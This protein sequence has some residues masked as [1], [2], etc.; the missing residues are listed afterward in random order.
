[1]KGQ[2]D[3]AIADFTETIRLDPQYARAYLGRGSSWLA[4]R[5]FDKALADAEAAIRIDPHDPT[6]L[7]ARG[8]MRSEVGHF[9]GAIADFTEA[10]RLN[11]RYAQAYNDGAWILATCPDPKYRDGRKAVEWATKACEQP[12]RIEAVVKEEKILQDVDDLGKDAYQLDTL[13]AAYAEAGDFD[14]AVKCQIKANELYPDPADKRKG[15]QRLELYRQR[16]P[17]RDSQS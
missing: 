9:E 3:K 13:A 16:K 5:E 8:R 14:A 10:V 11:P 7:H 4:K 12:A 15:E 17:Y 2:S 6:V 1:M